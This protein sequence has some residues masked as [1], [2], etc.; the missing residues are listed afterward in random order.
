MVTRT[1]PHSL[2]YSFKH[3]HAHTHTHTRK[4][5]TQKEQRQFVLSQIDSGYDLG[6]GSFDICI[7][8]C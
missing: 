6:N 1:Q 3:T 4:E 7:Q 8:D 5:H 2:T